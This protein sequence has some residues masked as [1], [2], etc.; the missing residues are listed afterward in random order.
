MIYTY[1]QGINSFKRRCTQHRNESMIR[2]GRRVNHPQSIII[3]GEIN[4]IVFGRVEIV[5]VVC[6]RK[7]QLPHTCGNANKLPLKRL[8]RSDGSSTHPLA[9]CSSSHTSP[10]MKAKVKRKSTKRGN[11]R[12]RLIESA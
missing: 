12:K 3:H 10:E 2:I 8:S 11:Y 4:H 1:V 7:I 6:T 5:R 9:R